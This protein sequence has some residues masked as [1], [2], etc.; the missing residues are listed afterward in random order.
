[1]GAPTLPEAGNKPETPLP[2]E[3]TNTGGGPGDGAP[4]N[5]AG[6]ASPGSPGTAFLPAVS[7]LLGPQPGAVIYAPGK[8]EFCWEPVQSDE[9][10]AYRVE[11]NAGDR[12]LSPWQGATCW[13]P[14]SLNGQFGTFD[15]RVRARTP[16]GLKSVWSERNAFSY[17]LDERPP[18]VTM[19]AP[20]LGDTFEDQMLIAVQTSDVESGVQRVYILAYYDDGSGYQWHTLEKMQADEGGA[21]RFLWDISDIEPQDVQV[22]V[23]VKDAAENFG[24]GTVE[25]L[26]LVDSTSIQETEYPKSIVEVEGR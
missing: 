13:V 18:E 25:R 1:M 5:S 3:E 4:E 14:D 19:V 16:G 24:F 12:I 11:I 17:F 15:W 6:V 23:Y 10:V 20:R 2:N 7:G 26:H 21:A 9:E 8:P 22:W